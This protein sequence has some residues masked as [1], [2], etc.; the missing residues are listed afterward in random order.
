LTSKYI[1]LREIM[2]EDSEESKASKQDELAEEEFEEELSETMDEPVKKEE[3]SEIIEKKITKKEEGEN[4]GSKIKTWIIILLLIIILVSAL[5]FFLWRSGINDLKDDNTYLI[6]VQDKGVAKAGTIYDLAANE[7]EIIN[8]E[9]LPPV[10]DRDDFL[11]DAVKQSARD[12]DRLVVVSV[13]SVAKFSTEPSV[14]YRGTQ[15]PSRDIPGYLSGSLHDE[16]LRGGDPD[17]MFRANLL[18]EWVELYDDKVS[19]ANYGSQA[20]KTV[21]AEY[22][23]G[24]IVIYPQNNALIIL[25]YIPLEQIFL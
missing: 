4:L 17:W 12:V 6:V 14:G 16:G 21:F 7:A 20:F 19:D 15:I 9:I 18:T 24:N 2:G 10:K 25:K 1:F 23:S 5:F 8:V 22:R 11:L 13:G 3:E